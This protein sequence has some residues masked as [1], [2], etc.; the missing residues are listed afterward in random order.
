MYVKTHYNIFNLKKKKQET[1][2]QQQN[3]TKQ[4]DTTS[5]IRLRFIEEISGDARRVVRIICS[6]C[7]NHR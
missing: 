7:W 5:G 6:V 2:Q 1:T 3:K 4:K